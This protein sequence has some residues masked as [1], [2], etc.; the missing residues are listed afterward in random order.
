MSG[1]ICDARNDPWT[2]GWGTAKHL[3]NKQIGP[4]AE[5]YACNHNFLMAILYMHAQMVV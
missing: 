1:S 4:R 5:A 3:T 2:A